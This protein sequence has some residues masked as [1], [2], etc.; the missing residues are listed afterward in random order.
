MSAD[1]NKITKE[2]IALALCCPDPAIRCPKDTCGCQQEYRDQVEAIV[3]LF[4]LD[5][6]ASAN[7]KGK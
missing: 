5:E 2:Q 4:H 7:T 1:Q 3:A 6:S